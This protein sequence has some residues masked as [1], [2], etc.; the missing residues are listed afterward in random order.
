MSVDPETIDES[1]PMRGHG[2]LAVTAP[3]VGN[4]PFRGALEI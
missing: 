3:G 2:W 1:T 4:G